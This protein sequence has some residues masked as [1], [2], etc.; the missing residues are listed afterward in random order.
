M[1]IRLV[2]RSMSTA[3]TEVFRVVQLTSPGSSCSIQIGIGPTDEPA[4]SVRNSYLVVTDLDAAR[5]QLLDR[6][7]EVGEIRHKTPIGG[8]DGGFAPGLDPARSDYASLRTSSIPTATGG[9]CR[10]AAIAR[11]GP[12]WRC[13][14]V[15]WPPR[16]PAADLD[17]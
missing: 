8:W 2:S 6:G 1:S 9:S 4:G 17:A 14:E 11:L 7:V 5:C 10:S 3:S 16:L 15:C 12:S 13:V